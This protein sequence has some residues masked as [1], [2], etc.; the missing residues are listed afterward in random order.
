MRGIG[1]LSVHR[2]VGAG[3][4][5]GQSVTFDPAAPGGAVLSELYLG[6]GD[7][8]HGVSCPS[9]S[10]CTSISYGGKALTFDPRPTPAKLSIRAG[11]KVA[12]VVVSVKAKAG[13]RVTAQLVRAGK[14]TKRAKLK[15][16]ADHSF[17]WKL[18][19]LKKGSYTARFQIAGK[20]VKTIKV[21]VT[22][23]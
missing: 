16:A 18:G 7:P 1:C 9:Q 12:L 23:A 15:V 22:A 4:A 2:C 6:N 3:P 11:A 8:V 13:A 21:T 14:V 17:T 19:A 20:T 5:L 10:Q